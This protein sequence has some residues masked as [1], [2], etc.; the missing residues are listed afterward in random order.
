MDFTPAFPL[1]VL[2]GP[3]CEWVPRRPQMPGM[4]LKAKRSQ[5]WLGSGSGCVCLL[6]PQRGSMGL[7]PGQRGHAV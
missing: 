5:G 2:F 1:P 6:G 7:S 4:E 3:W